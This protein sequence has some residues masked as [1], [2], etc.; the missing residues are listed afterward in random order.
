LINNEQASVIG[1]LGPWKIFVSDRIMEPLDE[2]LPRDI[3]NIVTGGFTRFVY[4][5]IDYAD[6]RQSR[7]KIQNVA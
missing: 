1:V 7:L 4:Y 6:V 2:C 3:E 5:Y